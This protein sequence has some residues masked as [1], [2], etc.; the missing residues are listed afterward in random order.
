MNEQP[1][2]TGFALWHRPRRGHQWQA[3]A[4][5]QTE[6]ELTRHMFKLPGGECETLPSG[7]HPEERRPAE[8]TKTQPRGLFDDTQD[9]RRND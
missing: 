8:M 7:R 6:A 3:V 4:Y 9:T 5:G 2:Q 1:N